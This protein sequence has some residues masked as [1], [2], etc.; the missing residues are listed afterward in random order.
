LPTVTLSQ[1]HAI[2]QAA[3]AHGRSLGLQPLTVAVLD[4]GGHLVALS[5]E[6]DSGILRPQIAIGKAWGALGMRRGTRELAARAL[7]HPGFYTALAALS[8]GRMV[9]V[10][11]GVLIQDSDGHLVGSVG[12]SGD[13]PDNDEKCA[14][15]AIEQAGLI[16]QTA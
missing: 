11:G 9:P 12:I 14:T 10:P 15:V 4:P 5:R 8:E 2:I 6:D 16:A 1:A 7:A 3:L 13:L